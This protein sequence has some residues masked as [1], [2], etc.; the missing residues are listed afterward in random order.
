MPTALLKEEPERLAGVRHNVPGQEPDIHVVGTQS[1]PRRGAMTR[2][3]SF[4]GTAQLALFALSIFGGVSGKI[5]GDKTEGVRGGL[6]FFHGLTRLFDAPFLPK[7]KEVPVTEIQTK[8]VRTLRGS[9]EVER[10]VQVSTETITTSLAEEARKLLGADRVD[11]ISSALA[12]VRTGLGSATSTATSTVGDFA[13]KILGAEKYS[14]VQSAVNR[15]KGTGTA[16]KAGDMLNSLGG[17]LGRQS[18]SE[19][20]TGAAMFGGAAFQSC[21]LAKNFGQQIKYIQEMENRAT[22]KTPSKLT[23][24]M[25]KR[26][27]SP[28]AQQVA[29]GA[30]GL[31]GFGAAAIDGG[32][33]L[34]GVLGL[35]GKLPNC[36]KGNKGSLVGIGVLMLGGQISSILRGGG[37]TVVEAMKAATQIQESGGQVTADIYEQIVGGLLPSDTRASVVEQCARECA[38]KQVRVRDIE[39]WAQRANQALTSRPVVGS[40][41][42]SSRLIPSIGSPSRAQF[43]AA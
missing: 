13:K 9:K 43:S 19:L 29:K 4:L 30:L 32:G 34:Y 14:G 26:R 11:Q 8:R 36:L 40:G 39:G 35:C 20:I 7:S 23:V 12:R 41:E 16:I 10:P 3:M 25:N 31:R 42:F 22:G 33:L 2:A 21:G 37:G 6:K 24:L 1:P 27:L 28:A 5:A 18:T 38:A 15:F 17:K